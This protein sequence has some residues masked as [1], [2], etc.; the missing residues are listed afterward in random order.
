MLAVYDG[1]WCYDSET[2]L[3]C[4]DDA[5]CD[6]EWTYQ[7]SLVIDVIE[8]NEYLREVGGCCDET[9]VGVLTVE[10]ILGACCVDC[11]CVGL[12]RLL[13]SV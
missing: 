11:E 4:N 3:D 8:G 9:G 2:M 7:S 6:G 1:C 13:V 10:I 5:Y 12:G